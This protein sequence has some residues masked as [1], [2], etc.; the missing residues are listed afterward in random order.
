M[1]QVPVQLIVAAFHDEKA[2]DEVLKDLKMA[3]RAGLI[4]IVNAA[5]LRKDEKGKLHIKET[6]DMRGGKGATIGGVTGAAIGLIAGS[7]LV[8]P[9][10][11][12]A[13]IGGLTA[14][15]RDSG[16]KD[17]RLKLIGEGLAPGSSAIVAV[18]E[19]NWVTQVQKEFE[20]LGANLFAAALSADIAEQLEAGSEVAYTAL[21]SSQGF[22][23]G[24]I[25]MRE[26]RVVGGYFAEDES[27]GTVSRFIATEKGFAVVSMAADEDEVAVAGVAGPYAEETST[28]KDTGDGQ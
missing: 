18:V 20:E 1:S 6:A 27:G 25:A 17:D 2:A 14:K 10:V 19:H 22:E 13:L 28:E 5:V 12:G 8:V 15:L 23:A 24:R 4:G 21:V 26:D 7:A 3:K 9:T 16:F 11:V